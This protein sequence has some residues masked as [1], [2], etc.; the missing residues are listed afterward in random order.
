MTMFICRKK[1]EILF[2]KAKPM[3]EVNLED[4][5][6]NPIWIYALDEEKFE[7]QDETWLKPVLNSTD[8]TS[9][10]VEVYILL[11]NKEKN[12][13]ASACLDIKQ[14]KLNDVAFWIEDNWQP[15]DRHIHS[16]Y[17]DI[18]YSIPSIKN[19]ANVCFQINK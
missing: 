19:R 12:L 10:M 8:V 16:H 1:E 15:F 17:P 5:Q 7:G 2:G 4:F 14:M 6:K 9:E 11:Q 18:F 13:Y 3:E